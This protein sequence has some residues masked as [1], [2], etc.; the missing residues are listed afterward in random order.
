MD[1]DE[2]DPYARHSSCF[3]AKTRAWILCC[4]LLLLFILVVTVP[5]VLTGAMHSYDGTV[6][7]ADGVMNGACVTFDLLYDF[8]CKNGTNLIHLS[9]Q[10]CTTLYNACH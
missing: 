8:G 10:Q 5:L 4:N 2:E 3:D 9:L 7:R 1:S 6:D